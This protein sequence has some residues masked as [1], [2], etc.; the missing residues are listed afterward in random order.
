M[1]VPT[2][3]AELLVA[4]RARL[5]RSERDLAR[6]AVA[7]LE[8][9]GTADEEEQ[10]A[11]ARVALGELWRRE[12]LA[13]LHCEVMHKGPDDD[14]RYPAVYFVALDGCDPEAVPSFREWLSARHAKGA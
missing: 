4:L 8:V 9:A 3:K 1:S 5:E 7:W 6:A 12:R 10:R 14:Y 2:E 13:M 11:R